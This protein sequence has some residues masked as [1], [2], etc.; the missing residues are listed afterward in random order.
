MKAVLGSKY[1]KLGGVAI[2]L[3]LAAAAI[4]ILTYT[5]EVTGVVRDGITD[6]P[7]ADVS[8][9]LGKYHATTDA[10]GVYRVQDIR[11]YQKDEIIVDA[12]KGYLPKPPENVDYKQRKIKQDI[13]L[14]PS[15]EKTA[16]YVNDYRRNGQYDLLWNILHPDVQAYLGPKKSYLAQSNKFY[17]AFQDVAGTRT[18][19]LGT[20]SQKLNTWKNKAT[21]KSYKN[22]MAVPV[23]ISANVLG[24]PISQTQK[25]HYVLFKGYYK[26]LPD[27]TKSEIEQ[28]INDLS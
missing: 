28:A 26:Y 22:V 20:T 15:L 18:Y 24:F 25:E 21:G 10:N 7:L 8:L 14:A 11:I 6:K 27:D 17:K 9:K 4:F 3:L 16:S 19:E 2:G 1:V 23:T 5:Y 13:A 12:T